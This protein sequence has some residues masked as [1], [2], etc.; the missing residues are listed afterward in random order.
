[1]P[2]V[3]QLPSLLP[4]TPLVVALLLAGC[5]TES[6]PSDADTGVD[7]EDGGPDYVRR[8]AGDVG[9]S[10]TDDVE[11][12]D[13]GSDGFGP[14]PAFGEADETYAALCASCHG[15]TGEG[16]VGP[17]LIGWDRERSILVDAIDSR[18][19]QADPSVCEGECA[20]RLADYILTWAGSDECDDA[21][22]LGGERTIRLLTRREYSNTLDGLLEVERGA[23][24]ETW[25]QCAWN[26]EDCSAGRCAPLACGDV[27]FVYAPTDAPDSVHLAGDFNDWAPSVE[28]GGWPLE[29]RGELYV[30]ER[31]VGE[32]SYAYKFVVRR[33]DDVQWIADPRNEAGTPDGFGGLNSVLNLRCDGAPG[34]SGAVWSEDLPSEVRPEGF[35]FETHAAS[36][37][38]T[39]THVDAHLANARAAALRAMERRD[40][41][42]DCDLGD[43]S[44]AEHFARTFG[45]RAFRRPLS[46]AEVARYAGYVSG[47]EDSTS[48][49]QQAL[50]HFFVS[51]HF[52]YRFELGVAQGDGTYVL[53]AFE[54]ASLLSYT[55]WGTLP[56]DELLDAAESGALDRESGLAQQARRLLADERAR[57]GMAIFAEQWLG[58]EGVEQ[59]ARD[60]LTDDMRAAL[61][62]ETRRLV[63]HVTFDASG[64]F[65][66]LFHADYTFANDSIGALYDV[67][68]SGIA[69]EQTSYP[70]ARRSGILGHGSIMTSTAH[71]D[72]T[73]PIRRG[74]WVRQRLLCQEFG[75]P[76][77]NAGGVPDVDPTATTR[78][79]FRQHTDDPFCASCHQYIDELGFGF[80]HF[81]TLGAWRDTENGAPIDALGN[82]ND[83][84]GFGTGTD[85]PYTSLRELAEIL[86]A[87]E[88]ARTCFH[89]Q[90]FRFAHGREE[91]P[92]DRCTLDDIDVAFVAADQRIDEMIVSL[93]T[94]PS[95]RRRQ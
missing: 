94:H 16:G 69:M 42:V 66:E 23:S 5:A 55:L 57:D 93:V 61:I 77:P 75:P 53:D 60:G 44:C 49:L 79:R 8:D 59:V 29:R 43:S 2:S 33:G 39:P 84:E 72:Q 25:E 58:I 52:L 90:Y 40:A 46:E 89:T 50:E 41:L 76:P 15:R 86:T 85:A 64:R 37:H 82:M 87:S 13:A 80:E 78:E 91:R 95:F 26:S 38:V 17:S 68:T 20:E 45:R 7:A 14:D 56:D 36:G 35:A 34:S 3:V 30:S 92:L 81:D 65:P 47:A 18:M 6:S 10:E 70:D 83:V 19:P 4:W 22:R 31:A 28:A 51:P 67:E 54:L 62:E 73:S 24:C 21:A 88:S 48:G 9:E 74:L 11:T 27:R 71:S 32:G 12:R 63:T 1:M